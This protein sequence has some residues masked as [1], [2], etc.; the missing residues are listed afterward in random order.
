MKNKIVL[1][2]ILLALPLTVNAETYC[3]S[4]NSTGT[5]VNAAPIADSINRGMARK[6][7]DYKTTE[8]EVT[9]TL[10]EFCKSNPYATT[11]DATNHLTNILDALSSLQ[12]WSK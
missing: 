9:R 6:G 4:V 2:L 10:S 11:E 12:R 5:V 1:S 8:G 7:I 3:Q